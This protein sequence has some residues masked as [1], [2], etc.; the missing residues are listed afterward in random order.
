MSQGVRTDTW[1]RI[2]NKMD[3]TR[4]SLHQRPQRCGPPPSL[5][6]AKVQVSRHLVGQLLVEQAVQRGELLV[7]GGRRVEEGQGDQDVAHGAV[8]Q[9]RQHS[10]QAHQQQLQARALPLRYICTQKYCSFPN[11]QYRLLVG[12]VADP[13]PEFGAFLTPGSGMGKKSGSGSGMNNPDHINSFMR[14]RGYAKLLKVYFSN[15]PV[16]HNNVFV[17]EK[18]DETVP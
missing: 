1:I 8:G 3:R 14:I 10:A 7:M 16:I 9:L 5:C 2:R 11:N 4:N 12:S 6:G 18:I 15:K 17:V 13:N